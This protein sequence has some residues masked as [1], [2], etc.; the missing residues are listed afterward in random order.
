MPVILPA[1]QDVAVILV[2]LGLLIAAAITRFLGQPS[3]IICF[4]R[5]KVP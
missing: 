3:A 2:Q 1:S 4:K 5:L